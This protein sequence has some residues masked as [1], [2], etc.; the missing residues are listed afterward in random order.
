MNH[1]DLNSGSHGGKSKLSCLEQAWGGRGKRAEEMSS[2]T[3]PS[4]IVGSGTHERSC[5]SKKKSLVERV[6]RYVRNRRLGDG[7]RSTPSSPK[8]RVPSYKRSYF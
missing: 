5:T 7:K 1:H 2:T 3:D 6:G 8:R 4:K